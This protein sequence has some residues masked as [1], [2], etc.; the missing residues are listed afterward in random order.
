MTEPAAS[1]NG[2]TQPRSLRP[3]V[4]R[5]V[6]GLADSRR[7]AAS[8]MDPRHRFATAPRSRRGIVPNS[9]ARDLQLFTDFKG[10]TDDRM[11]DSCAR[12]HRLVDRRR[13]FRRARQPAIERLGPGVDAA[14]PGWARFAVAHS[15][16]L[17]GTEEC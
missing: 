2:V 13:G 10:N 1:A 11:Q 9:A 7:L 16:L 6:T 8:G 15:S 4:A 17:R 3:R 12:A 14:D 5:F